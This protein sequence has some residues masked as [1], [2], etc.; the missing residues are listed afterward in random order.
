MVGGSAARTSWAVGFLGV[1]VSA[2]L[3]AGKRCAR[4]VPAPCC[5]ATQCS[6]ADR[7]GT[8]AEA[9]EGFSWLHIFSLACRSNRVSSAHKLGGKLAGNFCAVAKNEQ[10]SGVV[11]LDFGHD[12]YPLCPRVR[13]ELSNRIVLR[14]KARLHDATLRPSRLVWAETSI[15]PRNSRLEIGGDARANTEVKPCQL[16]VVPAV[17]DRKLLFEPKDQ[18]GFDDAGDAPAASAVCRALPQHAQRVVA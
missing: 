8:G 17:R 13:C 4:C 14:K 10:V 18:R 2:P 12:R 9:S 6:T 7:R 16:A 3:V 15:E 5:T 11:F 1:M